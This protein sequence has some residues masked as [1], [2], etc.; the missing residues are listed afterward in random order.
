MKQAELNKLSLKQ[1]H[2][3]SHR[4]ANAVENK[5]NF[6]RDKIKAKAMALIEESGFK[7]SEI[8]D[9][10]AQRKKRKTNGKKHVNPANPSQTTSGMGRPPQWFKDQKSA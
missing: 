1:L 2:D 3:L 10:K 8:M 7:V 4:V 9:F 5:K 6:E